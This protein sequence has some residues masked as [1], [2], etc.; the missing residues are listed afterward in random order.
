MSHIVAAMLVLSLSFAAFG[1]GT[2]G[3][4]GYSGQGGYNGQNGEDVSVLVDGRAL[5]LR[6]DGTDGTPGG[7][8]T[9]GESASGC[10]FSPG[11]GREYGAAGGSGGHGG[12]GGS[13][14]RGGHA[15]FFIKN[16]SDLSAIF[17]SQIGG[18]GA[19]GGQPGIGGAGCGC[20][21]SSW[22][23]QTCDT[24]RTCSESGGCSE[25][26][27][28]TD[29]TFTC[30]PGADGYPGNTGAHGG[31]GGMGSIRIVKG[32][33]TLPQENPYA[34]ISLK[35]LKEKPLELS[36]QIWEQKT[37][38][39]KLFAN[40]SNVQDS[41]SQFVKKAERTLILDW[42]VDRE[43]SAFENEKFTVAFDGEKFSLKYL[44]QHLLK[45]KVIE[46]DTSTVLLIEEAF[47]LEDIMLINVLGIEGTQ[48]KTSISIKDMSGLNLRVK[49]TIH[50]TLDHKHWLKGWTQGFSGNIPTTALEI[51]AGGI[52]VNVGKLGIKDKILKKGSK[53][54]FRM[55]ISRSLETMSKDLQIPW[56]EETL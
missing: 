52:K 39:K 18:K 25:S 16:I 23:A 7:N 9:N 33:T 3:E 19:P 38:A 43:F 12:D 31:H 34:E 29:R 46:G 47:R 30:T 51:T 42:K 53:V 45:T 2:P 11:V 10:Y 15:T 40:N 50:M 17:L 41:Y 21:P 54:R 1:F 5:E 36:K 13:G 32:I 24:R 20:S 44:G 48:S 6:L 55:T 49:T 35:A 8:A 28:C 26:R 27:T 4:G 56:Q 22:Q 37:G 14:G